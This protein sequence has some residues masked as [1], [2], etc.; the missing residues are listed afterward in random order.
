MTS[1]S[2]EFHLLH[3]VAQDA[4]ASMIANDFFLNMLEGMMGGDD[5][6]DPTAGY[7]LRLQSGGLSGLK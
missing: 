3:A 2:P 6:F 7:S 1:C 5:A 4:A